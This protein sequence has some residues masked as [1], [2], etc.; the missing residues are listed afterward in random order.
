MK[1]GRKALDLRLNMGLFE[2]KRSKINRE[3]VPIG[4]S[5]S[6]LI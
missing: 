3:V 4:K 2:I 5:V 6:H 1:E